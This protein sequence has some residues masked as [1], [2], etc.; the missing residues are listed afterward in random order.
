MRSAWGELSATFDLL[1]RRRGR[2][3]KGCER[4]LRAHKIIRV[5]A[6]HDSEVDFDR[7]LSRNGAHMI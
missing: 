1:K 3:K 2:K 7:E 4:N 6:K 5:R